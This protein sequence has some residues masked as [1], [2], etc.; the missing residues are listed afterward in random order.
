MKAAIHYSVGKVSERVQADSGVVI[1]KDV[2]VAM[3]ELVMQQ[4]VTLA[5]DLEMF[6]KYVR[7]MAQKF[8][9]SV[10]VNKAIRRI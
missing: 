2:M 9:N 4:C 8:I 5:T 6:A 1:S 10:L 7:K 3:T